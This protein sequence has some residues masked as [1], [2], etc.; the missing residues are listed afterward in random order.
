MK[1]EIYQNQQDAAKAILRGKFTMIMPTSTN[2]KFLNKY[3]NV[4]CQETRGKKVLSSKS[5][6]KIIWKIRVEI[7]K[8]ETKKT[9]E[10]INEMKR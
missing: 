9:I 8:T 7:T 2:K 1:M 4:T 10:N 3:S 5:V 6:K